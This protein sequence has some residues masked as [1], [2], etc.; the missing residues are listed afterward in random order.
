MQLRRTGKQHPIGKRFCEWDGCSENAGRSKYCRKHRQQQR[1][2]NSAK[3]RQAILARNRAYY[4]AHPE[5][6]EKAKE[7]S[8]R[9]KEANPEKTRLLRKRST[10]KARMRR[11]A[12]PAYRAHHNELQNR[13]RA[14][15]SAAYRN[16]RNVLYLLEQ[17][18][19]RCAA[20]GEWLPEER[21][22]VHVDH[23]IPAAK[24][25][26]NDLRNLQLLHRVCN[27]RKGRK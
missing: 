8:K 12:D 23:I 11:H 24:G 18:K 7:L 16:L 6:R 4:Q 5:Y 26:T 14:R 22:E 25:G 19:G 21:S 15:S 13:R 2:R 3:Y 20:C 1:Y 9:W 10:E 17:Q 27:Q